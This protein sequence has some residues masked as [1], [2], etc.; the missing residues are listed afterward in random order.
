[1]PGARVPAQPN[2]AGRWLVTASLRGHGKYYGEM[3]VDA[4]PDDEFTTTVRLTSVADGSR[5]VRS[6]RSV[7]YGGYAWRGRSQGPPD[8]AARPRTMH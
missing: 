5:I 1:M 7:V 6:G 2:L 3:Q 8:R 4:T